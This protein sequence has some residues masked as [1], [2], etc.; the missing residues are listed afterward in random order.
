[1]V[2]LIGCYALKWGRQLNSRRFLGSLVTRL[3]CP[4]CQI[5]AC[6]SAL[7]RSTRHSART[8]SNGNFQDQRDV[9]SHHQMF[10]QQDNTF[11]QSFGRQDQVLYYPTALDDTSQRNGPCESRILIEGEGSGNDG[12]LWSPRL[13]YCVQYQRS[14]MLRSL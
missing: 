9:M 1:M 8:L 5:H 6:G 2:L 13:L 3:L 12:D 4:N 7:Y 14:F 11:P 10:P